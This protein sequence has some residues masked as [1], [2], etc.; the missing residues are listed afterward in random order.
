[1]A[2]LAVSSPAN[3]AAGSTG[4]VGVTA[5]KAGSLAGVVSVALASNTNGVTGLTGATL[6]AQS[7]AVTGAAYDFA[8]ATLASSSLTLG[9]IRVG[10]TTNLAVT[11]TLAANGNAAYQDKLPSPLPPPTPA[12]PSSTRRTSPPAAAG[13]VGVT[14]AVAGSLAG[15]VNL[16]LTSKALTAPAWPTSPWRRRASCVTGNRLRLRQPGGPDRGLGFGI[17]HVG[18]AAVARTISVE[19]A[20]SLSRPVRIA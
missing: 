16:A 13:N 14:A 2:T 1:M 3:L 9:N 8:G 5:A 17:H 12:S 15:T 7:L 19:N 20:W 4:Y 18:A 11:N 10:A 6:T